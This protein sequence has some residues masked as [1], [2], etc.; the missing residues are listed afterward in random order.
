MGAVAVPPRP[1]GGEWSRCSPNRTASALFPFVGARGLCHGAHRGTFFHG[2]RERSPKRHVNPPLKGAL[3]FYRKISSS[4]V[5]KSWVTT[6]LGG[7]MVAILVVTDLSM[8][9]EVI[10]LIPAGIGLISLHRLFL[11]EAG[12]ILIT[13]PRLQVRLH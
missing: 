10:F 8:Q 1:H 13:D 3:R 2:Y 5:W 6:P 11:G 7:V 12:S 9:Q 4:G